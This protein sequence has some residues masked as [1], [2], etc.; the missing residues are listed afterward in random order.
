MKYEA[1]WWLPGGNLQTLW[2]ALRAERYAGEAPTFKRERWATP[3]NDFVDVD[4]AEHHSLPDAP[5]LV[6][7]H[8]L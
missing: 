3:D 1:P 4:F 7:F 2:A 8:G 6:V 5:L